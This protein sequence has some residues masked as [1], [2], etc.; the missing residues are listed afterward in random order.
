MYVNREG[1]NTT[2][3]K[4]RGVSQ[5]EKKVNVLKDNRNTTQLKGIVQ[6]V[7][8]TFE[9][10][11]DDK[12]IEASNF[13][14][15]NKGLAGVFHGL[16]SKLSVYNTLA[17]QTYLDMV[18]KDIDVRANE[19]NRKELLAYLKIKLLEP[20]KKEAKGVDKSMFVGSTFSCT[21]GQISNMASNKTQGALAGQTYSNKQ[22]YH[23]EG[24]YPDVGKP[25]WVLSGGKISVI[26]L[27][28]HGATNKIYIKNEGF[29]PK[30]I[31]L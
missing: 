12:K 7:T 4:S 30:R 10:L 6:R 21:N 8:K 14:N 9:E 29:G 18:L 5:N 2:Q 31:N 20:K 1:K 26:G 27:Y 22:I 25:L 23:I 28:R 19:S 15:M 17:T 24:K 11:S 16:D 3:L 13:F